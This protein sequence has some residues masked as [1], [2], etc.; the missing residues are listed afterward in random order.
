MTA[1]AVVLCASVWCCGRAFPYSATD[2]ARVKA[3]G[4]IREKI[5]GDCRE[6]RFV[7][8]NKTIRLFDPP[9]ENNPP[10]RRKSCRASGLVI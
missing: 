1:G 3:S 10:H 8:A 9:P 6:D 7:D 5:S 2:S 4:G